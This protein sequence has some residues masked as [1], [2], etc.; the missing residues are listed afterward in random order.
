MALV[1][2]LDTN[3]FLEILLKQEKSDICKTFITSHS[4][5]IFI[6]DF[7][8]H[9]IGIILF[10]HKSHDIFNDFIRDMISK[11]R[12]LNLPSSE[13]GKLFHSST[14]YKLDFDDFYQ[15]IIAKQY[16]LQIVTMD[17][18]FKKIKDIKINFL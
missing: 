15:Y 13:Y 8:L 4:D 12:I 18:D 11:I 14:K 7:S 6:S 3:I 17:S 2:L 10:R 16:D 1:Y 9:S 5:Q